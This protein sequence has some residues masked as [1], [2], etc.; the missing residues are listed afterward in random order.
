MTHPLRIAR[1]SHAPET[2][3]GCVM[4]VISFIDGEDPVTDTPLSVAQPLAF[5]M[6]F[7]NDQYPVDTEGCIAPQDA[8]RL[9][10]LASR[11]VGTAGKRPPPDQWTKALNDALH[12]PGHLVPPRATMKFYLHYLC[13]LD[14]PPEQCYEFVKTAIDRWHELCGT[15]TEPQARLMCS[16]V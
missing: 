3:K 8:L 7:L 4:N 16:Y 9:L 6:Q 11:T 10:D 2:G 14:A 1:G 5:L 13:R 12:L 15:Q